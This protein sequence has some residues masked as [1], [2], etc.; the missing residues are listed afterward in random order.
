M[1]HFYGIRDEEFIRGD[2]PMTKREIRM[3]VMNELKLTEDSVV[4]D[5][6]A[7]TGSLSIE[8]ALGAPEGH[9][10]AIERFAKGIELIKQ[11]VEKFK[12]DNITIIEA[13]APEGMADLPLLDAVVIGGTAGGMNLILDAVEK[14]LKING[15]L[16]VTAVT[17]ETGYKILEELKNRPFHYDGYLMQVNRFRKVANYHMLDPL[18]PIFIIAATKINEEENDG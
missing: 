7:G 11:N 2:V 5:V 18:S 6:G 12:I 14:K 1:K 15:R 3:A 10:Y 8:A 17:M 9:V 13:K 16:V 4:L